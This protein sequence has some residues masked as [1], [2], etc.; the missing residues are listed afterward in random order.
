M[1]VDITT[2]L[3][4][5]DSDA[6]QAAQ[7]SLSASI[8]AA[9]SNINV[10]GVYPRS[11]SLDVATAFTSHPLLSLKC[12]AEF[13]SGANPIPTHLGHCSVKPLILFANST[14][15]SSLFAIIRIF[16]GLFLLAN[17]NLLLAHAAV[18]VDTPA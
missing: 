3:P 4:P 6:I 2:T 14:E 18:T 8:N 10:V 11:A 9:S 15:V 5:V 7:K 13:F 1:G 17:A 12:L 16:S